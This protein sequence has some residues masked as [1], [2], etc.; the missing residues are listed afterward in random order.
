[1]SQ[2]K[3]N[4]NSGIR[5]VS[6]LRLLQERVSR[7]MSVAGMAESLGV[8][9]KTVRRYTRVLGECVTT[10]NGE[11]LLRLETRGTESC[12]RLAREES[13]SV[14][15]MIYRHAALWASA[16]WLSSGPG[17]VL[18]D[19]A[20]EQLEELAKALDRRVTPLLDRLTTAFHYVPFG[21]KD[22]RLKSD[23]LEELLHAV[24][25]C[26]PVDVS[27]TRRDG[28]EVCERL[29]PFTLVM[30]RD[31]LYLLARRACADDGDLRTYALE[32]FDEVRVDRTS[33]FEVPSDFDPDEHF[34][35]R[36]GLWEPSRGPER[37]EL[38]F[39]SG[40]AAVISSRRWPGS[41]SWS[42]MGDGR[43]VLELEIPVTPELVSWIVSWGPQVEVLGPQHLRDGV[44]SELRCALEKYQ[45][46]QL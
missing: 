28:V 23:V 7:S 24:I 26:R 33:S 36:L 19:M 21:A 4:Y 14:R 25:Y 34:K 45:S 27:R 44:V 2:R 18:G 9:V 40:A 10:K 17:N 37:I 31:G 35:L 43:R 16:Q 6:M 22:Y 46:P 42:E 32:R 30:Y 12:L 41:N 1:M 3:P 8:D 39:T 29:E 5:M 20:N 13:L 38:S 15:S 11:P